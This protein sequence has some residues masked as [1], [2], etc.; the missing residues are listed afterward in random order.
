MILKD[1]ETNKSEQRK[2][3]NLHTNLTFPALPCHFLSADIGHN[4]AYH[5]GVDGYNQSFQED[6][7]TIQQ[8]IIVS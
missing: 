6:S 4:K 3:L 7:F 2:L 5:Q 8:F 1:V